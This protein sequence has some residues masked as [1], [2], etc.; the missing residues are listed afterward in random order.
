MDGFYCD[1][2]VLALSAIAHVVDRI[3]ARVATIE[4][5]EHVGGRAAK[6]DYPLRCVVYACHG[7]TPV[8]CVLPHMIIVTQSYVARKEKSTQSYFL[9]SCGKAYKKGSRA[10]IH[11]IGSIFKHNR[12]NRHKR[13]LDIY[14]HLCLAFPMDITKRGRILQ[15]ARYRKKMSRQELADKVGCCYSTIENYERGLRTHIRADILSGIAKALGVRIET[16]V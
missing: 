6:A 7:V 12:R 11:H 8:V 2:A 1:A 5:V 3:C 14:I 16:L 15:A 13:K 4:L 9:R 10:R